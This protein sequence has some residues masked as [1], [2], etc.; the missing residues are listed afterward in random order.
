MFFVAKSSFELGIVV[1]MFVVMM[2]ANRYVK[3]NRARE[4]ARLKLNVNFQLDRWSFVCVIK[5]IRFCV[6]F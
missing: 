5:R 6:L 1:D 3:A 4:H 2:N